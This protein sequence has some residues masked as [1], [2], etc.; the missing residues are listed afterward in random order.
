MQVNIGPH[1]LAQPWKRQS[2]PSKQIFVEHE[3]APPSPVEAGGGEPNRPPS[4]NEMGGSPPDEEPEELGELPSSD[5]EASS[6][7]DDASSVDGSGEMSS[8]PL[9]V[10]PE[11]LPLPEPLLLPLDVPGELPPAV[12]PELTKPASVE[13]PPLAQPATKTPSASAARAARGGRAVLEAGTAV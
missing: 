5:S 10:V 3:V 7:G 6:E 1:P 9:G 12:E 11:P 13:S 2:N 4:G 8:P